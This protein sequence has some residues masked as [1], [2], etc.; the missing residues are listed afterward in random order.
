MKKLRY[1]ALALVLGVV[2]C[3]VVPLIDEGFPTYAKNSVG[4]YNVNDVRYIKATT[5]SFTLNINTA[6][7]GELSLLEGIGEKKAQAI[8]DYR[9]AN[10]S[11][12]SVDELVNVKGIGKATLDK[13]KNNLTIN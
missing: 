6:S 11:F 13:I 10:G 9:K 4:F 12:G 3:T 2:F 7:V 8:I 5:K 1:F